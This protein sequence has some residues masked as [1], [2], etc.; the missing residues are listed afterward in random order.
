[1]RAKNPAFL[2][3]FLLESSLLDESDISFLLAFNGL[4]VTV[5]ATW[6]RQQAGLWIQQSKVA[7]GI[8]FAGPVVLIFAEWWLFDLLTGHRRARRVRS[9]KQKPS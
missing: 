8:M 9:G 4:L 3:D 6:I 2:T 7:Q 1:M 5:I